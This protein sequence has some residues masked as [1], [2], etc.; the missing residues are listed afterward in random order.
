MTAI[1]GLPGSTMHKRFQVGEVQTLP[2]L[3]LNMNAV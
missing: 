1:L 3:P 2:T